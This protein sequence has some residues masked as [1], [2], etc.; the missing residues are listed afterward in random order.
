MSCAL[1][2]TAYILKI[3]E[4]TKREPNDTAVQKFVREKLK[5]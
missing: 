3:C 1:Q 5:A 2:A 4:K